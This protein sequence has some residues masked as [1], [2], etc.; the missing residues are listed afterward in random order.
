MASFPN[1]N[2]SPRGLSFFLGHSS[3][4]RCPVR[5]IPPE[6]YGKRVRTVSQSS[7]AVRLLCSNFPMMFKRL[8][9]C[10]ELLPCGRVVLSRYRFR[11]LLLTDGDVLRQVYLDLN[12]KFYLLVFGTCETGYLLL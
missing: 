5:L 6:F 1:Y 11:E 2:I 4:P 12:H 9:T 10:G 3:E 8:G 7:A